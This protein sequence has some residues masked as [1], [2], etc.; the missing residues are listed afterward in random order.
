MFI[1]SLIDPYLI[2]S[3]GR[4]HLF[5]DRRLTGAPP[6]SSA[7]RGAEVPRKFCENSMTHTLREA[8]SGEADLN[9]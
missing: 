1:C 6:K 9:H 7:L 2:A 4:D 8:P 3:A 5:F